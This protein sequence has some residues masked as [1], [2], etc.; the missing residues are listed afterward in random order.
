MHKKMALLFSMLMSIHAYPVLAGNNSGPVSM[1]FFK[2]GATGV[3][4]QTTNA[5]PVTDSALCKNGS[6]TS[7]T[8]ALPSSDPNFKE[9]YAAVML[10]H[11]NNRQVAFWLD[12]C[13][14][15]VPGGPHP[16]AVMVYVY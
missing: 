10:A 1:S 11:A 13:D 12:G 16:K 14:S 2:V 15:T 6:S 7:I 8:V 4:V 5:T 9:F 3:M